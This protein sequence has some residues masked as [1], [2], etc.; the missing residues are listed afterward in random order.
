MISGG[1]AEGNRRLG[2]A[3]S[4]FMSMVSFGDAV[5]RQS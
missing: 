4:F 2:N 1:R 3:L 5:L